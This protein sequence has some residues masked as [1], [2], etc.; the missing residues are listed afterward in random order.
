MA[1]TNLI[2]NDYGATSTYN[3]ELALW[4]CGASCANVA[5]QQRSYNG[6]GYYGPVA[7]TSANSDSSAQ[8]TVNSVASNFGINS[9][10]DA[11]QT[12]FVFLYA[13]QNHPN[14]LRASCSK[15]PTSN[16][17]VSSMQ[18]GVYTLNFSYIY[19]EDYTSI[20]N[21]P[22]NSVL[23]GDFNLQSPDQITPEQYA[24][25][26][27]SHELDEAITSPGTKSGVIVGPPL[28]GQLADPC[29]S[30]S[31]DGNNVGPATFPYW[32]FTRDDLRTVVASF[33]EWS[34]NTSTT[35]CYPDASTDIPPG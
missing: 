11:D 27:F 34:P 35:S 13:P 25:F 6:Q 31:F 15:D 10:A 30:R 20:C 29:N 12:V 17:V 33:V 14:S 18:Q 28:L 1:L 19:L 16:T 26:A 22:Q 21:G 7:P 5:V 24:T 32:N 9:Q 4:Y 2:K 8:S 3:E 23:G